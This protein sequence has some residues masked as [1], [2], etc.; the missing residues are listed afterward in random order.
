MKWMGKRI[1]AGNPNWKGG[2][3]IQRQSGYVYIKLFPGD[4]FLDMADVDRY[5]REHRLVMAKHIGRCLQKFEIVHH[6][7]GLRD[8]NR[9]ENLEIIVTGSNRHFGKVKCPYCRRE[10]N[11]T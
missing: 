3:R 1:G 2:R 9:I 11:I 8:D 5:V 6:R 10:F 4:F 7:N